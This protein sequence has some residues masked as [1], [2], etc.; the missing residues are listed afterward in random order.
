M[1]MPRCRPGRRRLAVAVVLHSVCTQLSTSSRFVRGGGTQTST[2]VVLTLDVRRTIGSSASTSPRTSL[3]PSLQI[4][5]SP[6]L[7]TVP[8]CGRHRAGP[9]TARATSPPT[10]LQV[11]DRGWWG[12]AFLIVIAVRHA[13]KLQALVYAHAHTQA[14]SRALTRVSIVWSR[15]L[16]RTSRLVVADS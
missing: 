9:W 8:G 14:L 5:R 1:G 3:S 6:D 2:L 7:L 16:L 10:I 11:C 13:G 12:A 15:D 4:S